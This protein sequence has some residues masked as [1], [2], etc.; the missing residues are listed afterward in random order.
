SSLADWPLGYDDLAPFYARIEHEVGVAAEPGARVGAAPADYPM[1]P[2]AGHPGRAVLRQGALELGWRPH[3]V[4]LAINSVPRHG[5][6]ACVR[7][8]ASVGFACPAG[9]KN[10]GH[11]TLLEQGLDGKGVT[12]RTESTVVSIDTDA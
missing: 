10:G 5:R 4:P 12:L 2:H 7:C 9:A 1:P 6:A 3:G 8:R 11:N